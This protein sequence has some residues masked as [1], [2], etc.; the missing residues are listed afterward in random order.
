MGFKEGQ[1][2]ATTDSIKQE[3]NRWLCRE[4]PEVFLEKKM[5]HLKIQLGQAQAAEIDLNEQIQ[6]IRIALHS[7]QLV[8]TEIKEAAQKKRKRWWKFW[9]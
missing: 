3:L 8:C 1:I 9:K 6:N 4:W 5:E 7:L 2:A